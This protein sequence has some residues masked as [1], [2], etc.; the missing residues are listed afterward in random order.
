MPVLFTRG[1]KTIVEE[2]IDLICQRAR[3]AAIM[4]GLKLCTIIVAA[5]G[6]LSPARGADLRCDTPGVAQLVIADTF[7]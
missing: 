7:A 2:Q 5:L 1:R 6:A 3:E 4:R